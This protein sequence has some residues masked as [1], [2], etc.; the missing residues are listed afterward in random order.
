MNTTSSCSTS[1]RITRRATCG[2]VLYRHRQSA[3][4]PAHAHLAGP[5]PR[6]ARVCANPSTRRRS[7]SCRA[8]ATATSRSPPAA[9]SSSTRS[10]GWRWAT[11][12][13]YDRPERHADRVRPAHVRRRSASCASAP[14]LPLHRAERRGGCRVHHLRREGLPVCKYTGWLEILRLRD[15]ASRSCCATAATTRAIYYRFAF[16]MGPERITMLRHQHRGYSLFLGQRPALPGAVL[17]RA[18]RPHMK[19]PFRG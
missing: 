8:C 13:T 6:H 3:A 4:C 16:G 7:S 12:I 19:V 15:G 2:I 14:A 5:D 11:N 17:E 1:R 9:R 18:T 10:K